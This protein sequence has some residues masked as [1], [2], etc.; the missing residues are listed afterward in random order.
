MGTNELDHLRTEAEKAIEQ[1]YAVVSGYQ[2]E[3]AK[4]NEHGAVANARATL[5]LAE[6][7]RAGFGQLFDKSE[8]LDGVF[9]PLL[10]EGWQP[11]GAS[12]G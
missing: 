5:Y 8:K 2:T 11:R 7:I 4:P 9:K 6:V 1:C 12:D 3:W 10:A